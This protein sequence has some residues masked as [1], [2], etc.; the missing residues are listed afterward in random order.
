ME[1]Y[2]VSNWFESDSGIKL[3]SMGEV[4]I[5]ITRKGLPDLVKLGNKSI[6]IFLLYGG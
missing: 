4:E 3:K 1:N 5:I 2:M 6:R